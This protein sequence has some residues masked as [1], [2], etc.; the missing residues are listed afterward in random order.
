MTLAKINPLLL[1]YGSCI[2]GRQAE[3]LLHTREKSAR[4]SCLYINA[5]KRKLI[6]FNQQGSI[7]SQSGKPLK[8]TISSATLEVFLQLKELM[9]V[10]VVMMA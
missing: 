1:R 10:V 2:L 4:E 3:S 6:Y 5:N 7:T 8:C 9:V